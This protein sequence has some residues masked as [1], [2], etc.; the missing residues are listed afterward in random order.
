MLLLSL[1]P[2]TSHFD[3]RRAG[4][5]HY[6]ANRL[7]ESPREVRHYRNLSTVPAGSIS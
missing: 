4:G 7:R 2:E 3:R 5:S 1:P 6:E